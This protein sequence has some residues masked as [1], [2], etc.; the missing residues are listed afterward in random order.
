MGSKSQPKRFSHDVFKDNLVSLMQKKR[1]SDADLGRRIGVSRVT[2]WRWRSGKQEPL[3]T[4]RDALASA[5]GV[6]VCRLYQAC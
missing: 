5:L 2:I 6:P 3:G 1:F 4:D